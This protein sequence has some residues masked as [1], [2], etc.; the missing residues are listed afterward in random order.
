MTD[1]IFYAP[2]SLAYYVSILVIQ[3][4]GHILLLSHKKTQTGHEIPLALSPQY[5]NA[6]S[7]FY[8][9][10]SQHRLWLVKLIGLRGA[11]LTDN[12]KGTTHLYSVDIGKAVMI[13]GMT[14]FA[15]AGIWMIVHP[16]VEEGVVP[17]VPDPAWTIRGSE[18]SP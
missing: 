11:H 8:T 15:S 3:I 7:F 10:N 17:T 6:C 2:W 18:S 1:S 9:D 14:V 4:F 5:Y 13:E 12:G 16:R